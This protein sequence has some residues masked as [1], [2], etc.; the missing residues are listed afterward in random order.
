MSFNQV[1]LMLI[2]I[3]PH[4]LYCQLF[5]CLYISQSW[6]LS[7]SASFSVCMYVYESLC[8]YMSVCSFVSSACIPI[9]SIDPIVPFT[10]C[11]PPSPSPVP[12]SVQNT[13]TDFVSYDIDIFDLQSLS[14]FLIPSS[15]LWVCQHFLTTRLDYA[16]A[17]R[18]PHG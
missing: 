7:L 6:Y 11:P 2:N 8:V 18:T 10:A 4:L 14:F 17:D 9:L 3:S 12:D 5:L 16:S 1:H 15:F 13:A